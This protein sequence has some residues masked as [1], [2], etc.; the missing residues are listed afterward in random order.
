VT[1]LFSRLKRVLKGYVA[2]HDALILAYHSVVSEPLPFSIPQHLDRERFEWQ[3]GYLA[4]HFRCVPLSTLVRELREG[5]VGKYTVVVTFDDGFRNNFLTAFPILKHYGIP[6]TIFVATRYIGGRSLVWPEALACILTLAKGRVV[7]I[8]GQAYPLTTPA[9]MTRAY[10]VCTRRFK[11]LRLEAIEAEI[12]LLREQL[13]ITPQDV[14]GAPVYPHFRLLDWS[15]IN[16]MLGSSLV[17]IGSHTVTHRR[18]SHLS[19]GEALRELRDSKDCIERHTGAAS[20]LAYPFGGR[21]GDFSDAHMAMA[22]ACGYEAAVACSPG[23]VVPG[24]EIYA[25]PRVSINANT[26]KEAFRYLVHGGVSFQHKAR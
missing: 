14:E 15:D 16:Q 24:S 10:K 1:T 19:P 25:L 9:E 8:D 2:R 6:A 7:H 26:G 18:L 22:K 17:E 12:Q 11:A 23:P 21:P 5:R 4:R 13:H 3:I 20:H